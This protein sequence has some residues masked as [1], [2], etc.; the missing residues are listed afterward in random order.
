MKSNQ[1]VNLNNKEKP[2]KRAPPQFLQNDRYIYDTE[3]ESIIYP[4]HYKIYN[5]Y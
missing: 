3:V 1:S 5:R 2:L 4:H